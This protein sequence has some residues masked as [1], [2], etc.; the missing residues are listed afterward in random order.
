MGDAAAQLVSSYRVEKGLNTNAG[1]VLPQL[2][3]NCLRRLQSK[4]T[5]FGY[6]GYSGK[7]LEGEEL[8][9]NILQVGP[10]N[11]AN[12]RAMQRIPC[13]GTLVAGRIDCRISNPQ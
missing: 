1:S 11:C 3:R 8:G 6:R 5:F 12:S 7:S 10:R 9:S 2:G 13:R 4:T